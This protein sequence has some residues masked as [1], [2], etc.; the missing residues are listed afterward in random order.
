VPVV[1]PVAARFVGD[2]ALDVE[3]AV[4][5][6]AP[7]APASERDARS[8]AACRTTALDS[9]Q[10]RRRTVAAP[11]PT[12]RWSNAVVAVLSVEDSRTALGR[13]SRPRT[14]EVGRVLA[15]TV[16]AAPPARGAELTRASTGA[17]TDEP[18]AA[19]GPPPTA[20]R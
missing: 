16:G 12:S 13:D 5:G 2:A 3:D 9:A 4:L 7:A 14:V 1:V 15:R 18:L 6:A 8:V 17:A 11:G 10:R 19:E 20:D